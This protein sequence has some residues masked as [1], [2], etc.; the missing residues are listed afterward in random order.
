[1]SRNFKVGLGILAVGW[2]GIALV[3]SAGKPEK[4]AQS[5]TG[6][7]Q[8]SQLYTD[9]DPT[10]G[11][12]IQGEII[13]P[14]Q[15]IVAIFATPQEAWE[16]VYRGE[17]GGDKGR[18]F[19]FTGLPLGKYDVLVVFANRFYEGLTLNRDGA[20]KP[21][22][23]TK[24]Q[25]QIAETINQSTPFFDTKKIHRAEGYTGH[26]GQ[27]RCVLQDLR[28]RPTTLQSGAV[29][30]DI[31]IRSLKLALLEDV[32]IGWSLE[33]TREF[34]RQEVAGT[35][36]RGLLPHQYSPRLNSIRVIDSVKDLGKISL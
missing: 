31:Q 35:E 15:T 2:A 36:F 16:K 29:R 21:P 18:F 25:A 22:L 10:S 30:A 11:G 34:L 32:N 3:L 7:E 24:D 28:T 13:A 8:S 5:H 33:N 14:D 26:A 27:A 4:A 17:V 23:T 1:M 12:G 6:T 19:R 9:M 20:E